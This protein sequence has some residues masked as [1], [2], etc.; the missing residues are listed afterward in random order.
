MP[1]RRGRW[2]RSWVAG[3]AGG[4]GEAPGDALGQQIVVDPQLD[5]VVERALAA[6]EDAGDT[7]GL[8]RGARHPVEDEALPGREPGDRLVDDLDDDIVGHQIAGVHRCRGL[9]ADIGARAHR[10][11]QHG[12][13]RQRHQ[14]VA[15]GK[16]LGLGTLSGTRRA[17]HDQDHRRRPRSFD[18]LIRPSYWWAMRCDW[19]CDTV[20]IV[21]LTTISSEVP[22]K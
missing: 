21:T 8:D 12:A 3:T 14:V 17:Q 1:S 9:A 20:S 7:L 6:I 4:A 2:N 22:P 5:D 16:A 18:F 19:I 15:L 10:R 13:G 11:T